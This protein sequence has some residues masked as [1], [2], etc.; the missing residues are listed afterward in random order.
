MP[1]SRFAVTYVLDDQ[2]EWIWTFVKCIIYISLFPDCIL[3]APMA[4]A[5]DHFPY[6]PLS[7][8][9]AHCVRHIHYLHPHL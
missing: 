3:K 2:V 9:F 5:K 4:T 8:Y 1:V 6:K 7:S